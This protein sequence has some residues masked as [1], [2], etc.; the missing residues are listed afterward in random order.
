MSVDHRELIADLAASQHGVV[1]GF[2]ADQIGVP[3]QFLHQEVDARRM[4]PLGQRVFSVTGAPESHCARA[5]AA[6]LRNNVDRTVECC[7]V[8]P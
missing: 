7:I 2:Q 3:N 4:R 8:P 5:M 1:A 6:V